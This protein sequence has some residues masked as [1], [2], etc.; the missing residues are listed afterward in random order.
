MP[1]L[2]ELWTC[3]HRANYTTRK[4]SGF[5]Q[6][7]FHRVLSSPSVF[8]FYSP[9]HIP[10]G[11]LSEMDLVAPEFEI[12]NSVT[13][14]GYLNQVHKWTDRADVFTAPELEEDVEVIRENYYEM[15]QD[16]EVLI[17][18]LDRILTKGRLKEQTRDIIVEALNG[19]PDG[20]REK[21]LRD[22][23]EIATYIIMISPEFN[24]LK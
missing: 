12:Y 21:M 20:N 19:L 4:G 7:T 17:N 11:V 3:T 14:I 6:N 5:F 16:P 18:F 8:N 15:A 24:I 13:S 2:P 10:N 23:W 22:R 1:H 9:D